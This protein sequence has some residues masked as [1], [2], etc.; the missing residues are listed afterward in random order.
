MDTEL[1]S[2]L[3]FFLTRKRKK[4]CLQ[5]DGK[6]VSQARKK[7]V[8]QKK[9]RLNFKSQLCVQNKKL[10]LSQKVLPLKVCKFLNFWLSSQIKSKI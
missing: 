6:V 1:F 4:F 2:K 8:V 5:T 7:T 3:Y 9:F 10:K